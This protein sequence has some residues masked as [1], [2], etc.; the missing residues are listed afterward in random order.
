MVRNILGSIATSLS[1]KQM[2][3]GLWI[4]SVL[5]AGLTDLALQTGIAY[6]ANP[7]AE[8]LYALDSQHLWFYVVK[9][10][11][12]LILILLSYRVQQRKLVLPF[13]WMAMIAYTIILLFHILWITFY[14]R[15]I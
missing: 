1:L 3:W 4:L 2:A 8:H 11:L 14:I 10:V 6:E 12:P 9:T 15:I 7:V 5:D 13:F